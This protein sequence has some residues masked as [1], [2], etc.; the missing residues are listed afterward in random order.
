MLRNKLRCLDEIS[1]DFRSFVLPTKCDVIKAIYFQ[2]LTANSLYTFAIEKVSEDISK[3]WKS[4]GIPC[5]TPQSILRRTTELFD[6]YQR[7]TK[8]KWNDTSQFKSD[9]F[10]V[11]LQSFE[12]IHFN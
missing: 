1:S 9:R 8:Q 4:A 11:N 2:K 6:K 10:K 5:I 7:I 12:M 3:I